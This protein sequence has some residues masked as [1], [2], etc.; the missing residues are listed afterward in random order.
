M[1][2]ALIQRPYN[3]S[4]PAGFVV[5]TMYCNNAC[6]PIARVCV[7]TRMYVYTYTYVHAD[8]WGICIPTSTDDRVTALNVVY[9]PEMYTHTSRVY[10]DIHIYI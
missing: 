8:T 10:R 9:G 2:F 7:R 5:L 1:V 6:D 3:R 4:I